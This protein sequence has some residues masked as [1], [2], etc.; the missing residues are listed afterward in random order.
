MQEN[1]RQPNEAGD[2]S[3]PVRREIKIPAVYN[4]TLVFDNGK[5]YISERYLKNKSRMVMKNEFHSIRG[6]EFPLKNIRLLGGYT[7]NN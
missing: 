5:K 1:C 7:K 6:L 2:F 4:C 3:Y